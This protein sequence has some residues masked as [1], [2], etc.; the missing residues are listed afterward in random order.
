MSATPGVIFT[1]LFYLK[2]MNGEIKLERCITLDWK[3]LLGSNTLLY[4]AHSQVTNTTPGPV[5]TTIHFHRISY[6]VT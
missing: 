5:L 2:L 1:T 3:G 4:W 6:S